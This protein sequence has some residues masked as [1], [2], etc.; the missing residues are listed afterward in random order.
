MRHFNFSVVHYIMRAQSISISSPWVELNFLRYGAATTTEKICHHVPNFCVGTD[1]N[2]EKLLRLFPWGWKIYKFC[3]GT[4]PM[5][6]H[7]IFLPGD[8]WGNAWGGFVWVSETGLFI[9]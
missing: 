7:A 9:F 8:A 4:I 3:V 6:P 5:H 2:V 1:T